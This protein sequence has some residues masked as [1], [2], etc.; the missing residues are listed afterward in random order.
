MSPNYFYGGC[1]T[2]VAIPARCVF[3]LF[4]VPPVKT[5]LAWPDPLFARRLLIDNYKCLAVILSID[6]YECLAAI[7][8]IIINR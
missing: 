8:L 6:N 1:G 7:A 4:K 2:V 3:V 5:I